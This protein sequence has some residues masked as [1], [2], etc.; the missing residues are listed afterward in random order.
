[1][2]LIDNKEREKNLI[3]HHSV[4]ESCR[5]VYDTFQKD[6]KLLDCQSSVYKKNDMY[7]KLIKSNSDILLSKS[8]LVDHAQQEER[9]SRNFNSPHNFSSTNSDGLIDI[10][11]MGQ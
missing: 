3:I 4:V 5:I 2:R 1:M 10:R 11:W 8:R 6:L 9:N 7:A